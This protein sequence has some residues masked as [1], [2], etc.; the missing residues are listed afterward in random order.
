MSSKVLTKTDELLPSVFDNFFRPWNEWFSN[1]ELWNK[2]MNVPAVNIT[3]SENDYKVSLAAPGLKKS[4]FKINLEGNML[5]ISSE[6]E[7]SKDEQDARYTRKEYSYSS[8]RR[9]FTMPEEVSPDKIEATYVDGVLRLT[10][11]KKEDAKKSTVSKLIA[12]N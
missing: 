12:V 3:E 9:S 1:N 11:P 6:K 7:E 10:L 4:D 5:T 2:A 8:F